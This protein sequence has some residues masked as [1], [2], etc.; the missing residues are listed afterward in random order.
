MVAVA[1][2]IFMENTGIIDRKFVSASANTVDFVVTSTKLEN[3]ITKQLRRFSEEVVDFTIFETTESNQREASSNA[4]I[5]YNIPSIIDSFL[6]ERL[7][8]T[9]SIVYDQDP[10][11]SLRLL[12]KK[13]KTHSVFPRVPPHKVT[14]RS[15]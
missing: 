13:N 1:I 12:L 9:C 4:R 2:H 11:R 5:Q 10:S 15:D 7:Q 3:S 8:M 14:S 6:Y